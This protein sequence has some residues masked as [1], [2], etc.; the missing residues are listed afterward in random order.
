[1]PASRRSRF[2]EEY[3]RRQGQV[4]AQTMAAI[5]QFVQDGGTVIAIGAV[6]D[7]RGAA[8]RSAG[9]RTISSRTAAAAAARSSTCPGAVLH[10]RASTTTIRSR[11]ASATTLDVFFDNDPVFTLAPTPRRRACKAVGWF[12]NATPLRSG[13]AWGQQYLDKGV[14]MIDATVGQ[15][16]LFLFGPEVLFRSQPHGNY[17]LFFNA[18]TSR[19]RR[20]SG[21]GRSLWSWGSGVRGPGGGTLGRTAELRTPNLRTAASTVTHGPSDPGPRTPDHSG[22]LTP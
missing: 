21:K 11:T 16:R 10:D 13:W 8:V 1:M 20:S 9:H 5:K 3:A 14:E 6:G 7:G 15:G 12:A 4:T 18:C 22:C 17:K 19:W 2:R